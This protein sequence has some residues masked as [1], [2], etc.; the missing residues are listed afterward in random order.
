LVDRD[1]KCTNTGVPGGKPFCDNG[2]PIYGIREDW[3]DEKVTA[4]LQ[5]YIDWTAPS[6]LTLPSLEDSRRARLESRL[7]R[8]ACSIEYHWRLYPKMP[9]ANKI[10]AARVQAR[11]RLVREPDLMNTANEYPLL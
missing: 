11:L 2:F 4:L 3:S 7:E 10:T 5:R 8:Q 9:G 1:Y 6:L